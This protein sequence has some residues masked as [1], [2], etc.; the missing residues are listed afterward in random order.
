[1]QLAL[2]IFYTH[3]FHTDTNIAPEQIELRFLGLEGRGRGRD[4]RETQEIKVQEMKRVLAELN[5]C[6]RGSLDL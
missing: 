5:E 6:F 1:M 2:N 3:R 4:G